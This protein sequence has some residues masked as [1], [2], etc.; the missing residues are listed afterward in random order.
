MI[1]SS[2]SPHSHHL[3]TADAEGEAAGT[4][5]GNGA[6]TSATTRGGHAS[7]SSLSAAAAKAALD[8]S[9]DWASSLSLGE[10]Q[11]LGWARLLLARPQPALALLDEATS[12]LDQDTE[13]RLYKVRARVS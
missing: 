11:R 7:P 8:T 5:N 10:Q 1:A 4:A 6:S 2:R 9:A 13:A 12:A 3:L